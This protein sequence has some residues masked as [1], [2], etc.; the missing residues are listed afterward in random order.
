MPCIGPHLPRASLP[1]VLLVAA[2]ASLA[3]AETSVK[4]HTLFAESTGSRFKPI[5]IYN[6]GQSTTA[7]EVRRATTGGTISGTFTN[8]GSALHIAGDNAP[9]VA[10]VLRDD[11]T[12]GDVVAGDGIYTLWPIT[13]AKATDQFE[14]RLHWNTYHL[15]LDGG[16][17][18]ISTKLGI[19]DSGISYATRV[20]GTDVDGHLITSSDFIVNIQDDALVDGSLSGNVSENLG[21]ITDK[22]YSVFDDRFD[23]LVFISVLKTDNGTNTY[24]GFRNEVSGLGNSGFGPPYDSTGL[25]GIPPAEKNS[26]VFN[27]IAYIN[28]GGSS[29]YGALHHELMHRWGVSFGSE[30][31]FPFGSHWNGVPAPGEAYV[32]AFVGA[33]GG[34]EVTENGDNTITIRAVPATVY[35]PL[36]LYLMGLIGPGEVPDTTYYRY[37]QSDQSIIE[38]FHLSIDDITTTFGPRNPGVADSQKEFAAAFVVITPPGEPLTAAETAMYSVAAEHFG[39]DAPGD[40]AVSGALIRTPASFAWGTG[41]RGT[42]NTT[43]F[44]RPSP[45][46][47]TVTVDAGTVSLGITGAAATAYD[48][49][50]SPDLVTWGTPIGSATTSNQGDG[51]GTGT[52]DDTTA[53]AG[54]LFYRLAE[55]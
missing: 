15:S 25:F 55:Q 35:P 52:Y 20:L 39:S 28:D 7:L 54:T 5:G 49:Y 14:N 53:G 38:I 4:A 29:I 46:I 34:A 26:G 43:L 24:F 44:V 31:G 48:V 32:A 40:G 11:G 6:D 37:N 9:S 16:G 13:S 33:L 12:Q 45:V 22:L 19:V 2:A 41:F 17:G 42:M 47:R 27:G 51:T 10:V 18:T 8:S 3:P 50:R 23:Y 21:A 1:G 30:L 36:E